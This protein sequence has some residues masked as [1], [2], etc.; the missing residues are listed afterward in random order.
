MTN[1]KNQNLH[2]FAFG[3]QNFWGYI[4]PEMRTLSP[5]YISSYRL[6]FYS[7]L[8]VTWMPLRPAPLVHLE[9]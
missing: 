4:K 6:Y 9:I 7:Q 5:S 3:L 1:Q 2:I 8:S